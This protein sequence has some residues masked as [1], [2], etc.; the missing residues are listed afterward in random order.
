MKDSATM[1]LDKT[2]FRF[3]DGSVSFHGSVDLGQIQ[4]TPFTGQF[5]TDKLNVALLLESLDYLDIPA[6]KDIKNC[7]AKPP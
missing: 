7:P 3:H 4:S 2:G 5:Q 6:F 1:V